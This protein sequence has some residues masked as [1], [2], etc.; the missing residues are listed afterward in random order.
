MAVNMRKEDQDALAAAGE[1]WNKANAAGDKAGMD[2][3]HAQAEAI[4]NN[5]GYSGGSDGSQYISKND[6]NSS[7]SSGGGQYNYNGNTV[8]YTPVGQGSDYWANQVGMSAEDQKLLSQYGQMWTDAAAAGDK[9]GMS[10]AA[11]YADAIRRKYGYTGGSDG[12]DYVETGDFWKN[13]GG[14]SWGGSFDS[15]YK[16][17]MDSLLD[18]ILNRPDFSYDYTKDPLYQQY[19]EVYTREGNRAMLDT[20]GQVAAR[21]GGLASSYATAAAN[22]ANN[23]YMSQLGDKI[24]ELQQLAY[25]M[26]MDDYN[27]DM[28]NM[29]LLMGL[30]DTAYSRWNNDRNFNYGVFRDNISDGRYEDET[31]YNRWWEQ[32]QFG[33]NNSIYQDET[34]YERALRKA[35]TLAQFGNFSGYK[36]LGYSDAEIQAMQDAWNRQNTVSYSSGGGSSRRSSG[37][38]KSSGSSGSSS[39]SG[40]SGSSDDGQPS[41]D[42]NSVIELGYGPISASYLADLEAKGEIVSYVENGKIKYKKV[43]S[44]L[45]IPT[46]DF[47]I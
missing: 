47:I 17:E 43:N 19:A 3:A 10:M 1:A 34:E 24:P 9:T 42:M 27:M 41:I 45:K 25:S 8:N 39:S 14:G 2:A 23:Y 18:A 44:G 30:D 26:W 38:S 32:Y 22:Q 35:E 15:E 16:D 33:Q 7:G 40:S 46:L 4:R 29:S 6:D 37:S 31:A 28:Q 36:A 20:L 11:G 5:Y 13:G 12:S 21:T